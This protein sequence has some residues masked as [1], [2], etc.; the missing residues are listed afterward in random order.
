MINY[1]FGF[2]DIFF[3]VKRRAPQQK[4]RPLKLY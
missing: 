2:G 1:L 4:R 3:D